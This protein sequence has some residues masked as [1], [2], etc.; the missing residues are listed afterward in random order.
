MLAI[1]KGHNIIHYV[2]FEKIHQRT[3]SSY[4]QK[5]IDW[6]VSYWIMWPSFVAHLILQYVSNDYHQ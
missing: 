6:S 3:R 2:M 1:T 4:L 5:V